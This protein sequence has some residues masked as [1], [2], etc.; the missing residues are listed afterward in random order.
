MFT[1]RNVFHVLPQYQP[2]M[3]VYGI[4]AEG[5]FTH[6][7]IVAW[8]KL[9]DRENC[10]LD[11]ELHGKKFRLHIKRYAPAR[12][13]TTRAEDEENALRALH[14]EQIPTIQLVG[15]GKLIDRRSFIITEDLAGYLAAD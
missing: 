9:E 2:I 5:I 4:D 11:G 6:P 1:P 15:W 3:R 8:R 13:F 14:I 10:T 7:K 12:G